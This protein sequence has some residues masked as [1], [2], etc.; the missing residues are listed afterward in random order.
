M[1][2]YHTI[3]DCGTCCYKPACWHDKSEFF[4]VKL[5]R[6]DF[7]AKRHRDGRN[8]TPLSQKCRIFELSS[9]RFAQSHLMVGFLLSAV[10]VLPEGLVVDLDFCCLFLLARLD[11]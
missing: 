1:L 10:D 7:L 9:A 4:M 11:S 6:N 8:A 3:S 5:P 2:R